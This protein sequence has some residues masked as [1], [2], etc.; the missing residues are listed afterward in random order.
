[1]KPTVQRL[2]CRGC[3]V[4]VLHI[5]DLDTGEP[6]VLDAERVDEG[7]VVVYA[8]PSRPEFSV[9]RRYGRPARLQPAW[10]EHDCP[11]PTAGTPAPRAVDPY[12]DESPAAQQHGGW[13]A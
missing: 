1:M 3:G 9:A 4:D 2:P 7:N 6:I 13:R 10:R 12:E 11:T 5:E 8:P